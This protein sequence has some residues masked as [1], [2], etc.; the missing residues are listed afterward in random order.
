MA[1]WKTLESLTD[2]I[3]GQTFG[4]P[5]RHVPIGSNGLVDPARPVTELFGILHAPNADGTVSFGNGMISTIATSESA[6]VINRVDYPGLV[7]RKRDKVRAT[8]DAGALIF[9]EVSRVSDRFPSIL[10][11]H[12]GHV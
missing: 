1:D 11:L 5:V 12:L 3:V 4:E 2:K 7:V 8:S 10:V 9:Y 6:L